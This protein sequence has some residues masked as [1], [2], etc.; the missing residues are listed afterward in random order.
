MDRIESAA[1]EAD[2]HAAAA[3][4]MA[5]YA[6]TMTTAAQ[7]MA[8]SASDNVR[9]SMPS[10][11]LPHPLRLFPDLPIAKNDELGGRQLLQTHGTERVDFARADA[12]LRAQAE[13]AAVVEPRRSIHQH[14]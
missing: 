5:Q 12:D 8:K 11:L 4:G 1:E 2:L 3:R 6:K 14:R 13:L 9:S 10:P 7:L